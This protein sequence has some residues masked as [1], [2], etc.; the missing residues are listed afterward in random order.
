MTI[1][2]LNK[3]TKEIYEVLTDIVGQEYISVDPAICEGYR[4]GP[5][6]YESGLGYERVMTCIPGCVILPRTTEEVQKIVRVCNR[7]K[8]PYIPYSTGFYGPRSHPHVEGALLI[9][10]KRM[11]DFE[12]DE[13]HLYAVVGTGVIYSQLQQESFNKNCY[14]VIGGGGAQASVVA[15]LIGDGWSPLSHRIGLPHRRILGTEFVTPDGEIVKMGSLATSDDWFWGECPGPDL[16][17]MLRGFTGLRGCLGIVTKM[18]VKLL[19]FQPEKLLPSGISPNTHLDLPPKRVKWINFTVT[20]KDH[21][22]DAM[23][24]IAQAEIGG[25]VTKVPLFWRALAKARCKEEF[26]ELWSKENEQTVASFF[27][28]R[29]ML[30]AFTSEAQME[31]EER[32]LAD[33]MKRHGAEPRS[34]K[35]SDESWLKN[36]D[37]AGMWLMTGSY[38]S[39]DYIIET[40]EHAVKH[41]QNYANLKKHYTPPLMPDYGDPGWFQSF[42]L[43]HQGY[44]EFLIYWDQ[45]ENTDGVDHFYLETSKENIKKHFYTSLLGPHQPLYLTGPAFGPNYHKWML[46]FKE[47]FDPNWV[48]HPPV[49]F[50]HDEFVDRAKWMKPMKDWPEPKNP[51]YKKYTST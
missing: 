45:D 26:W 42:E 36:A 41:G 48:S 33:I 6:G 44:S 50:A 24:E 3:I 19:P 20:S 15:N 13:R 27:V 39:V 25:A 49:P 30:I 14:V 4:S 29:V 51:E 11:N 21:L 38:V 2:S 23:Y 12:I 47:E 37:S 43:G 10:M 46:A 32:V 28:L 16:R 34:T 7:F 8:V 1:T 17:G 9:D 18:A 22:R 35:P 5:G 40:I 31:Y